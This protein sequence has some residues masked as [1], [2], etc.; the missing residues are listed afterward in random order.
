MNTLRIEKA[1]E[2]WDDFVLWCKEKGKEQ[3]LVM[4]DTMIRNGAIDLLIFLIAN[5]SDFPP[6]FKQRFLDA[7]NMRKYLIEHGK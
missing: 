6:D 3:S 5:D 4:V 2:I 1:Q 7:L